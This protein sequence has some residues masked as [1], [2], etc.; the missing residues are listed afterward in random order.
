MKSLVFSIQRFSLH[1][2]KGIRTIIF[3]KGCPLRCIWCSNP[4]SQSFEPDLMFDV[5]ICKDF[6]DCLLPGQN[7]IKTGPNGLE[8]D[9]KAIRNPEIFRN[10]CASKAL[11]VSGVEMSNEELLSEIEKDIPFYKNGGGVTLSGGE[12][13]SQ[14]DGLI[15]LLTALKKKKIDVAIETSLHVKWNQIERCIPLAGTFLVDLKHTGHEKFRTFTGGDV[16]LVLDNLK[17][18]HETGANIILRVPVIPGFNHSLPEMKSIIDV[19]APMKK[20]S[21]IHFL[22]YHTMGKEKYKMLS[23]E[24]SMGNQP[25][26]QDSELEEYIESVRSV[27][28][29]AKIGG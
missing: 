8:I 4:E 6:S 22:P 1:D 29:K 28:L 5:R 26:V 13:L 18:L 10:I 25:A 12:P 17:K 15:E 19:A 9:R 24:Y 16:H 11:I 7:A 23:M 21:E 2:G 14:G 3:F 27:G 20:V